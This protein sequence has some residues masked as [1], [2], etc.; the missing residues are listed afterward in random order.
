MHRN[1][2]ISLRKPENTSIS[3]IFGFSNQAVSLFFSNLKK[4][5]ELHHFPSE[6]I[7]NID[8]TGISTVLDSPKVI[9]EKGKRT[10][11]QAASAERGSLV[12]MVGIVNASGNH[13]PPIYVFPR[14]RM[15]PNF[16]NGSVPGSIAL[17]ANNGWM[18]SELFIDVL[19]HIRSHARCTIDDPI[20][21]LMDN[22]ASHCS[23]DSVIY[24]RD[25]GI[26]L[27]SFP[28][29]TSHKLQPLDVS[30]FG[31][32]KKFCKHSFNDFTVNNP[33]KKIEISLIAEL[34]RTPFLRAFSPDNIVKGFSATGILPYNSLIFP[35]S[36]FSQSEI[37]TN[38]E[39][40]IETNQNQAESFENIILPSEPNC[41][42][43]E[44]IRPLPI[45]RKKRTITKNQGKSRIYTDSPEKARLEELKEQSIKKLKLPKKLKF[46]KK[47]KNIAK[48]KN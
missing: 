21:L 46:C 42:S 34:T 31:P 47:N 5:Y 23:L 30:V 13:I 12:T 27:L 25:N 24:S 19:I 29:H 3:R 45:V 11:S 14:K 35:Q 33:G 20:L 28:P 41:F 16:L 48:T 39:I 26:C 18:N 4:V 44:V 2:E 7:Y 43:P 6:R 9:A 8:E 37:E 17:L 38:S 22:H 10:V 36:D 40:A 32:F 1:K 15:N